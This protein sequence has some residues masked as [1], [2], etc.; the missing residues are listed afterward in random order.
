MPHTIAPQQLDALDRACQLAR[1]D[2]GRD[3]TELEGP[4]VTIGCFFGTVF[5]DPERDQAVFEAWLEACQQRGTVA[6]KRPPAEAVGVTQT[7]I[8][9][10]PSAA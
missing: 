10:T 6:H 9:F 2:P 5:V 1:T 7:T 3:S 4:P 8:E